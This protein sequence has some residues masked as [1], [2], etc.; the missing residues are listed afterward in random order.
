MACD[1]YGLQLATGAACS[2]NKQTGSHV[3]KAIGLDQSAADGSLRFSLGKY[4]TKEDIL[5]TIE[6]IDNVLR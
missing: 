3:L 2:A 4:T 5:R 1:E 6:I